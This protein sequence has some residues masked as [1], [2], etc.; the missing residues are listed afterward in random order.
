[1][2]ISV[3]SSILAGSLALGY[4]GYKLYRRQCRKSSYELLRYPDDYERH[5]RE[6]ANPMALMYYSFATGGRRET[7]SSSRSSFEK[8]KLVPRSMRGVNSSCETEY[9]GRKVQ[10]PLIVAPT[11]IHNLAVAEGE[12]ATAKGAGDAG[13]IYCYNYFLASKS[14]D[15]I[16]KIPGEK[17]LHL[18]I[19]QERR[20]VEFAIEDALEKHKGLFSAVIITC[21]QYVRP[22]Q[23]AIRC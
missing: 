11:A 10:V 2:N 7:F 15:E 1:M 21:D 22:N 4:L 23:L 6:Y 12:C 8:I 17:W 5:A 19:F 9:F 20:L 14:I 3:V 18:Y 13:V 16:A